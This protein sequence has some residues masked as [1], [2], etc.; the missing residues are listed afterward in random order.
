MPDLCAAT[1]IEELYQ[2]VLVETPLGAQQ[3]RCHRLTKILKFICLAPYFQDCLSATDLDELNIELIRNTV[4][5]AYLEDFY[6]FCTNLGSSTLD[7]MHKILAFEPTTAQL[8]SP[9]T[10][11]AQISLKS[12]EQNCS[13]VSVVSGLKATTNSL[14]LMI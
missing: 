10:L 8:T 5:K 2:S 4:Y 12:P 13:P 14:K 9:S 3:L 7:V 1:N 6:N 11:L